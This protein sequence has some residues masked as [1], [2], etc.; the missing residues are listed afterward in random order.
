MPPK[1]FTLDEALTLLPTVR[2]LITEIQA[3]K[4]D[5]EARTAELERLMSLSG[6]N[7][8]HAADIASN[9][10][11]VQQAGARLQALIEELDGIGVEL[12]G[13]DDGLVD[14]PSNREGRVVCLCW[15][16]GEDTIAWWHE[17]DAGFAGRQPL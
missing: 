1:L 15:R 7:G 12:K 8:H 9:R 6:G 4:A 10:E 16:L 2:Q 13:V 3:A 14:F 11:L 17:T 5:M